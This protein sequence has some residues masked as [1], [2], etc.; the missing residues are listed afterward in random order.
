[1][2]M[3]KRQ[4]WAHACPQPLISAF[5][6]LQ[7]TSDVHPA[8]G[9]PWGWFQHL[10]GAKCHLPLPSWISQHILQISKQ[11]L[12]K[13]ESHISIQALHN[14]DPSAHKYLAQPALSCFLFLLQAEH[15]KTLQLIF[16]FW[17]VLITKVIPYVTF[18]YCRTDQQRTEAAWW[19]KNALVSMSPQCRCHT[20]IRVSGLLSRRVGL[21]QPQHQSGRDF[22]STAGVDATS[23]LTASIPALSCCCT[24]LW[25]FHCTSSTTPPGNRKGCPHL[26]PPPSPPPSSHNIYTALPPHP[27]STPLSKLLGTL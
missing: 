6:Q 16:W 12:N 13:Q 11:Y 22:P 26:N 10:S 4:L 15:W 19:L 7:W 25:T 24:H 17:E 27:N 14:R 21:E 20:Q 2:F 1:M 23:L 9:W 3:T 5:T 18:I 8:N